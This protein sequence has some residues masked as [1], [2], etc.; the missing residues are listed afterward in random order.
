M[1]PKFDTQNVSESYTGGGNDLHDID[2]NANYS[3]SMWDVGR[4][5][6]ELFEGKDTRG[7]GL[8]GLNDPITNP[9]TTEGGVFPSVNNPN[10]SAKDYFPQHRETHELMA[11]TSANL[12]A[13]RNDVQFGNL[14]PMD[15]DPYPAVGNRH[16][17]NPD[18]DDAAVFHRIVRGAP[19]D[20]MKRQLMPTDTSDLDIG[21]RP[22]LAYGGRQYQRHRPLMRR[23]RNSDVNEAV[24]GRGE[25]SV[26]ANEIGRA[27]PPSR[28]DVRDAMH[29]RRS[30]LGFN[31]VEEGV[32]YSREGTPSSVSQYGFAQ[33]SGHEQRDHSATVAQ[34]RRDN[35]MH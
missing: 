25:T 19:S 7:V 11:R 32:L 13:T 14:H 35:L 28:I 34:L 29:F 9:F 3:M 4:M 17:D 23:S 31:T 33:S 1:M 26:C 12:S 5:T 18:L 30:L 16:A 15:Y 21:Y 24:Y 6:S 27:A 2:H 20:Y 10:D 8:G 22:N